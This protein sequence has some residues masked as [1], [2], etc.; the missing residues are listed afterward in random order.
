MRFATRAIH[1][2][3]GPDP[4]TGDTIPAIHLSTTYTQ[5]ALNVH[6]GYEYSRAK[7]PTR[8]I[9][10]TC[11]ASLEEA[12]HALAFA[13]GC[14]AAD[15]VMHL[16]HAGDHILC[17]QELYGG[18]YR[19]FELVLKHH[20]LHFTF[21]PAS[22]L[23][24]FAAAIR[25]DTKCIWFETPTNPLLT[26]MDIAGIVGLAKQRRILTALD[27][28]FA[29][30]YYQRPLTLGVDLV[31]HSTTKYLGGHSDVIGGAVMCNDQALFDRLYFIQKSAGAVPSPFDCW[32]TL[33]G[34]K[35]LAVRMERHTANATAVAKFLATHPRVEQVF[36]PGVG[37]MVSFRVRGDKAA[38]AAVLNRFTLFALAESL[39]GVESL[40]C[41]PPTMTHASVPAEERQRLGVTDN[42]V[43]LSVGIEDAADLIADLTQALG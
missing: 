43:R 31:V 42:L 6:K 26:T 32:L 17:G 24:A 39:G 15:A 22:D 7:N 4:A 37:G 30:P 38:T 12:R 16:F 41:Y 20:G 5:E 8:T 3:Q 34:I 35:T 14:A 27:N 19:L 11:L 25:P 1:A 28:T 40:V 2:G 9:L 18:S 13:S 23:A 10:E 36:Y 29:T 33:R 21:A